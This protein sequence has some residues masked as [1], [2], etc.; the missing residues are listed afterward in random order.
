MLAINRTIFL[1]K[2]DE[3]Q[4]YK[5]IYKTKITE[6]N[7]E[8]IFIQLPV[9]QRTSKTDY[10]HKG[11]KII[12]KV[13]TERGSVYQFLTEIT[14]HTVNKIP[15]IELIRPLENEFKKIQRR[16]YVRVE[17]MTEVFIKLGEDQPYKNV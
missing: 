10:F 14:N 12:A 13:V 16:A 17:M 1:E 9:N 2:I 5:D 4:E 8:S 7:N 3:E 15:M 11:S 6:V